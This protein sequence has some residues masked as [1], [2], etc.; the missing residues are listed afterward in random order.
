MANFCKNCGTQLKEGAAF[1][2]ECGTRV[3]AALFDTSSAWDAPKEKAG[4]L[5]VK[6]K[7]KRL[8]VIIAVV[9]LV[10][11]AAVA[12]LYL[13]GG[14]MIG[15]TWIG[16]GD[17]KLAGV[18]VANMGDRVQTLY[19]GMDGTYLAVSEYPENDKV[20][21]AVLETYRIISRNHTKYAD[22]FKSNDFK[23]SFQKGDRVI[24]IAGRSVFISNYASSQT[25]VVRF[26]GKE[27]V[28]YER[29]QK[30]LGSAIGS[31]IYRIEGT[32]TALADV[33]LGRSTY[34]RWTFDEYGTAQL[35]IIK[36]DSWSNSSE[37]V[38]TQKYEYK[39]KNHV[40]TLVRNNQ[41][42]TEEKE[43]RY[44]YK[45]GDRYAIMSDAS[46]SGGL[47]GP[48]LLRTGYLYDF[49]SNTQNGASPQDP[50][51]LLPTAEDFHSQK[52]VSSAPQ[53]TA[54]T[55]QEPAA[56]Y[57][58][59]VI[60]ATCYGTTGEG[61]MTLV[62]YKD[63]D[64]TEWEELCSLPCYVGKNGASDEKREGDRCT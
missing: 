21:G 25:N 62:E 1:C 19:Y 15:E 55:V 26:V 8:P 53:P 29:T 4:S 31:E 54:P 45:V 23:K 43:T 36:V 3:A 39:Y 33:S 22:Y 32:F 35:E 46:E 50:P 17:M 2:P 64:E 59:Q 34:H 47:D 18:Y 9:L 16:I 6:K 61:E 28:D 7:R 30:G 41:Y 44:I 56:S 40:I 14:L 58:H 60:Y 37:V 12:F 51:E 27:S 52:P 20:S 48:P 24:E 11:A 10:A 49:S 57:V 13:H 38:D 5:P 42:G 63:K